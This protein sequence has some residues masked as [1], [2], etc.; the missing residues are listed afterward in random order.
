[1]LGEGG[2]AA[3]LG[4]RVLADMRA[5]FG[6]EEM[7]FEG[8]ANAPLVRTHSCATAGSGRSIRRVADRT[9]QLCADKA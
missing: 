9:V 4:F 2:N 3:G 1:M 6:N 5:P 8:S 7:G